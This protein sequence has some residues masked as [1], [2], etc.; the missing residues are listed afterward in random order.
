MVS[1]GPKSGEVENTRTGRVTVNLEQNDM[2]GTKKVGARVFSRR[3]I[4]ENKPEIRRGHRQDMLL[5]C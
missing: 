2:K 1:Y 5:R 4:L 3:R